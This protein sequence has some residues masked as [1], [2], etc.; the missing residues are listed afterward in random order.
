MKK[1]NYNIGSAWIAAFFLIML[2][3]CAPYKKNIFS[4]TYHN[5][6]AHY[7][8]YFIARQEIDEVQQA[9]LDNKQNDYNKILP[10]FPDIDSTTINPLR[11]KLK[12]C[13]EKASLPIQRHENSKWVDDCYYLV[14][15]ARFYAGDFVNAIETFKYVNTESDDDAIRHAALIAL[16]RTF[17][18]YK[19]DNNAFAVSDYLKKEKLDKTNLKEL[20]LTRAYLYQLRNDYDNVLPN[21]KKAVDLIGR[22]K[23]RAR[24]Y[25]I[26]GQ[27]YQEMGKD[28]LSYLGLS[29]RAEKQSGV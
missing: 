21:L 26:L 29:S 11:P 9:I 23:N 25:F 7:N 1:L 19:E 6:T 2:G 18:H 3:S 5:T 13:I 8:A 14:G 10:V 24:Y 16:M 4:K 12:D 22:K 28:S 20:Y 15:L 27:I 17:I